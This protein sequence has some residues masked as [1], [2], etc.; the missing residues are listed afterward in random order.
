M[1]KVESNILTSIQKIVGVHLTLRL[2]Q[3]EDAEYVYALR[4]DP[5]YNTYLSTVTGTVEDQRKW[6]EGYKTREAESQELYYVI[7]R[8]D[9]RRCGLVRLYAIGKETFTWGSWI[10]DHNKPYKAALESAYLIYLTAFDRLGLERSEFDVRLEN[11]STI[12]FHRRFGA[13]ET[14]SDDKN[15]YFIYP[16]S[17]YETDRDKHLAIIQGKTK[18]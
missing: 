7:E 18:G 1:G 9:G 8:Q 15:V 10:L 6:I 4:T 5:T 14:H 13:T 17:Q 3:P 2:I 16:R 12:K 11:A